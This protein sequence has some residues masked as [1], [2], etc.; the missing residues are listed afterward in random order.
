MISKVVGR[1]LL[2]QRMGNKQ[3]SYPD[4]CGH[5]IQTQIRPHTDSDGFRAGSHSKSEHHKSSDLLHTHS[6][7]KGERNCLITTHNALILTNQSTRFIFLEARC[8]ESCK[9]CLGVRQTCQ[10]GAGEIKHALRCWHLWWQR[11]IEGDLVPVGARGN[12]PEALGGLRAGQQ[13]TWFW[14]MLITGRVRN[15]RSPSLSLLI[16]LCCLSLTPLLSTLE[17]RVQTGDKILL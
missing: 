16:F 7:L 12:R 10:W 8:L 6:H 17:W 13:E 4:M 9:R 11:K 5:Q 1:V 3:V 15:P 2:N 14:S